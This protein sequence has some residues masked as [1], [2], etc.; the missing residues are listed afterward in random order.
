M[1]CVCTCA[2]VTHPRGSAV[3]AWCCAAPCCSSVVSTDYLID[4]LLINVGVGWT[5]RR[6]WLVLM[7]QRGE[8]AALTFDLISC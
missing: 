2:C 4:W 1:P 6:F 8:A 5:H 7:V 3:A